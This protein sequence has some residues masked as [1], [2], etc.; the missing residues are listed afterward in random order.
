M[1]S[2]PSL[3]A[4]SGSLPLRSGNSGDDLL[5]RSL[6]SLLRKAKLIGHGSNARFF[7]RPAKIRSMQNFKQPWIKN[8]G[9]S[10]VSGAS[11][12]TL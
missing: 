12:W 8:L 3:E 2:S 10:N 1:K 5:N 11:V 6:F 4:S 7:R 9:T